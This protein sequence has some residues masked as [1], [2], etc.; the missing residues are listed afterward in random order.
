M[1][2]NTELAAELLLE[3]SETQLQIS[4]NSA[5]IGLFSGKEVK[6][7]EMAFVL[8]EIVFSKNLGYHSNMIHSILA[9]V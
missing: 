5:M 3:T 2:S 9:A 4:L 7:R 6:F 8:W 1:R